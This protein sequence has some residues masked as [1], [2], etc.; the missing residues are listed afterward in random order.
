MT[1]HAQLWLM[2]LIGI[3]GTINPRAPF[4]IAAIIGVVFLLLGTLHE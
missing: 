1:E 3:T 4:V 2:L